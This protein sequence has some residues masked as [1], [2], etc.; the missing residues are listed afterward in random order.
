MEP[1]QTG[2]EAVMIITAHALTAC[3]IASWL[4]VWPGRWKK[5]GENNEKKLVFAVSCIISF[6][7]HFLLDA[8]PHWD[9]S[10]NTSSDI[11]NVS[12]ISLDVLMLLAVMLIIFFRPLGPIFDSM[13]DLPKHKREAKLRGGTIYLFFLLLFSA[14]FSLLPDILKN[15]GLMYGLPR[16]LFLEGVH[17]NFHTHIK[18]DPAVGT[19]MLFAHVVLILFL[20][21][22]KKNGNG[23]LV[24]GFKKFNLV[25]RLEAE[26]KFELNAEEIEEEIKMEKTK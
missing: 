15:L 24:K 8:L 23:G 14:F 22:L 19:L 2:L 6:A 13:F 11:L 3:W 20:F 12:V 9:Y 10:I 16:L 4:R 7:S 5:F 25:D 17:N 1:R 21:F 18:L 26:L